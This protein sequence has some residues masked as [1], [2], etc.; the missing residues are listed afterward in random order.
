MK[1]VKQLSASESKY[2]YIGLT[3]QI[4]EEFPE[5][6]HIFKLKFKNIHWSKWVGIH[7]NSWV[8]QHLNSNVLLYY[9]KNQIDG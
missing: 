5:K 9:A 4:R 3:K 1:F 7:V 6:D 2:K 8:V